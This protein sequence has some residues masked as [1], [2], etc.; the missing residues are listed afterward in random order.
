MELQ[1]QDLV[2]SI[3]HDGIEEANKEKEIIINQGKQEVKRIIDEAKAESKRIINDA[4]KQAAIEKE[5]SI[6]AVKQ[7]S[8]DLVLS[9]KIELNK[10][11]ENLLSKECEKVF[12]S[13]AL[14][15]LIL[16]AIK[17]EEPGKYELEVKK[18]T[19][20]LKDSLSK[21]ISKGLVLKTLDSGDGFKLLEKDGSGYFDFTEEQVAKILKPYLGKLVL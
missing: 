20:G 16:A 21:E 5:G 11:F 3:K 13:D 9:L 10:I 1:I 15:K 18:V 4:Q 8:R 2:A 17:E 12:D 14:T 7:A 19:Q 6:A